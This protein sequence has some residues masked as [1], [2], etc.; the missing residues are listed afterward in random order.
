MIS[1]AEGEVWACE[2][3][4]LDNGDIRVITSADDGRILAY[5]PRTM[6]SLCESKVS[7]TEKKAAKPKKDEPVKYKGGAST[8][9]SQPSSN[10]S[11]CVTYNKTLKHLAV[12]NNDGVVTI[13]ALDWDQ[14]DSGDATS[15]DTVFKK[16]GFTKEKKKEWIEIM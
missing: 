11:R 1:H 8:Q 12:A 13:R 10:Q 2:V 9:S 16:L 14:I 3:C 7:A 5:N 6:K 15:I 4:S